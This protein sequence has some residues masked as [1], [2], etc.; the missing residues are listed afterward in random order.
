MIQKNYSHNLVID[1]GAHD[2]IL[3]TNFVYF[4]STIYSN[5]KNLCKIYKDN[6]NQK[7]IYI[8]ILLAV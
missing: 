4:L 5:S 8:P 6:E 3:N 7:F 1:C 2:P